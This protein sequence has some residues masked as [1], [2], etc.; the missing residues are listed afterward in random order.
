MARNTNRMSPLPLALI[1]WANIV[2]WA[3]VR[4]ISDDEISAVLGV[5][6]LYERKKVN[7]SLSPRWRT[8]AGFWPLS[9]KSYWR[10]KEDTP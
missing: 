1:V 2:K 3:T 5:T 10:D 4:G 8:S 6:R 9:R 7:T